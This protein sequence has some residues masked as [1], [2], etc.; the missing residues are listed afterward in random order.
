MNRKVTLADQE[1]LQMLKDK[2]RDQAWKYIFDKWRGLW[3]SYI[4]QHGGNT[5]Q[6]DTALADV[7]YPFER[8]V[9][10]Q[11]FKL[12]YS[13]KAYLNTCVRRQWIRNMKKENMPAIEF[14]AE[15]HGLEAFADELLRDVLN[16][17]LKT[18]LDKLLLEVLGE[19]CRKILTSFYSG[20]SMEEIAQE[21]ELGNEDN[22]KNQKH[23]CSN[24]LRDHLKNNPQIYQIL[25]RLYYD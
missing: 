21:Y 4:V 22:A 1:I 19:S 6:A 12:E 8:K 10:S 23:R 25:K 5:D 13:L 11:N 24:K 18:V 16:E 3:T 15:E 9:L 17:E 7:W 2:E 14:K 20:Y